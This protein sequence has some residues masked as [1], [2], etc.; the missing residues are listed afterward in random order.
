MAATLGYAG[1]RAPRKTQGS[2]M[3]VMQMGYQMTVFLNAVTFLAVKH[4]MAMWGNMIDESGMKQY[5]KNSSG[6][7]RARV[8][9]WGSRLGLGALFIL[10]IVPAKPSGR[11][12]PMTPNATMPKMR[13]RMVWKTLTQT[14]PR[15]PPKKTLT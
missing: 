6:V 4:M 14:A 9:S 10:A 12:D 13:K 3:A 7:M 15:I 5:E 11:C 8:R 2:Q 1:A